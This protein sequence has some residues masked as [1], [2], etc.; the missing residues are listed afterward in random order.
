MAIVIGIVVL[1]VLVVLVVLRS[2]H[3]IGP[4]EVGLVTKRVGRKLD[5]DQLLALER[6]G[7]L[8]GRRC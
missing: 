2:F 1:A 3:S 4:S 5:A 8:P 7:R 6:R